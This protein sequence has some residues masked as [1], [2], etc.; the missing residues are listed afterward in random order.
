V[1]LE[2]LRQV[3][4][5]ARTLIAEQDYSVQD[6]VYESAPNGEADSAA[7]LVLYEKG[8]LHRGAMQKDQ[9]LKVFDRLIG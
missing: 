9:V 1:I 2:N 5:E 6:A 7:I 3:L 4:R 8:N